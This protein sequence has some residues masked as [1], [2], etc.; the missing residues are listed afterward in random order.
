MIENASESVHVPLPPSGGA[1]SFTR[2]TTVAEGIGREQLPP[3]K[4]CLIRGRCGLYL[5]TSAVRVSV[6]RLQ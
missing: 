2:E 4:I 5:L 6:A 3:I 1:S